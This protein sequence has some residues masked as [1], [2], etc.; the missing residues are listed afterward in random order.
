MVQVYYFLGLNWPSCIC[1]ALQWHPPCDIAVAGTF[2]EGWKRE[3]YFYGGM[4]YSLLHCFKFLATDGDPLL[5]HGQNCVL[6]DK[7]GN[8]RLLGI[9]AGENMV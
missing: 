1:V 2:E 3:I 7:G 9:A 5:L 6:E 8:E 4:S